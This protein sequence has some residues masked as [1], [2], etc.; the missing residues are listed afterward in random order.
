MTHDAPLE[1]QRLID[2][3]TF[4]EARVATLTLSLRAADEQVGRLERELKAT[5]EELDR[6]RDRARRS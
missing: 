6:L 2:R 4:A 5:R 1:H 3:L